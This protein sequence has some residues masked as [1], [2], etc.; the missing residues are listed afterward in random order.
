[1]IKAFTKK[2]IFGLCFEARGRLFQ[3]GK[4]VGDVLSAG[5]NRTVIQSCMCP[6]GLGREEYSH[7]RER[8]VGWERNWT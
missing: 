8:T 4:R 6:V 1:M 2:L 3:F 5:C 7:D